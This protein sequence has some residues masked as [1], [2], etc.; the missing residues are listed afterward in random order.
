MVRD[1]RFA[2]DAGNP[3]DWG[4][5]R[6]QCSRSV[7][8]VGVAVPRA[9]RRKV[10]VIEYVKHL[11]A[12]LY[13]EVLGNSSDLVVFEHRKVQVGDSRPNQNIAARVA[14]EI[15]ALTRTSR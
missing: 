9:R 11:Q 8:D 15:K 5:G 14:T 7:E 4:S 10:R 2:Q 13:V 6:L 3:R 12:E 1:G